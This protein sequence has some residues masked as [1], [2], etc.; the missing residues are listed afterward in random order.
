MS[1]EKWKRITENVLIKAGANRTLASHYKDHN[2]KYMCM[3]CCNTIA[4][5]G[6]SAFKV[7]KR[8]HNNISMHENVLLLTNIIFE[9]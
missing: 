9:K 2:D 3:N 1:T 4:V 8:C 6:S 5:N 7:V